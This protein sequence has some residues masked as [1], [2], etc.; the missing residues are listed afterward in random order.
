MYSIRRMR[1]LNTK[2]LKSSM[3]PLIVESVVQRAYTAKGSIGRT[4]SRY[5]DQFSEAA[6]RPFNRRVIQTVPLD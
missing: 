5:V 2:D 6:V 1:R 3:H 4:S